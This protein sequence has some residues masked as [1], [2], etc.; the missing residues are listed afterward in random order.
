MRS[1]RHELGS[2]SGTVTI[3]I[4]NRSDQQVA[5]E[6]VMVSGQRVGRVGDAEP[7]AIGA[8]D[9]SFHKLTYIWDFGDPGAASDKLT[10]CRWRI[11]T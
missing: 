7:F 6:A 9:E 2:G 8:Y 3:E 1:P 10:T 5:P 11:T 4:M